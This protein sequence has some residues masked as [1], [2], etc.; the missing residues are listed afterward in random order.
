MG[1]R[2][3]SN[4]NATEFRTWFSNA[5]EDVQMAA[6]VAVEAAVDAGQQS[7]IEL[8]MSRGTNKTWLRPWPSANGTYRSGSTDARYDTGQMVQSVDARFDGADMSAAGDDTVYGEYG[9]LNNQQEYFQYQELGFTHYKSGEAIPAM[10]ALRDSF[11]EAQNA[12]KA[13]LKR[14]GFKKA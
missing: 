8:I 1:I 6:D 11:V 4:T 7:M 2:V 14:Q 13:E 9:W 5:V 12:L 10:N 3:S